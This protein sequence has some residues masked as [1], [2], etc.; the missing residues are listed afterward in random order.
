VG[1]VPILDLL[2]PFAEID[3][4]Q[5]QILVAVGV[6]Q[7]TEQQTLGPVGG[8]WQAG[9]S[10]HQESCSQNSFVTA[11]GYT[12]LWPILGHFLNITLPSNLNAAAVPLSEQLPTF[13]NL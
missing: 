11:N 3:D 10:S 7:E 4:S 6:L 13:Q 2:D 9:G 8:S 12:P 1:L 5:L